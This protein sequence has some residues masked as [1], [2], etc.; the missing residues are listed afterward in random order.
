MEQLEVNNKKRQKIDRKKLAQEY[1]ILLN[2]G[3]Y[4]NRAEL[5]KV[6]GVSRA[7]ITKVMNN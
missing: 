6:F 5:A 7:W 1:Q 3:T 4:K 2:N